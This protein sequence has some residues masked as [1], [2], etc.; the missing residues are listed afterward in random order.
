MPL[1]EYKNIVDNGIIDTDKPDFKVNL[2]LDKCISIYKEIMKLE[3]TD[4]Y[5]G[6][7]NIND[8]TWR[9]NDLCTDRY[10]EE[11]FIQRLRGDIFR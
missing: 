4:P 11:R 3:N 6:M 10:F 8:T 5:W 7:A 2:I 9:L 1:N